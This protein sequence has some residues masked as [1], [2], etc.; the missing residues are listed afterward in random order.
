MTRKP[1]FYPCRVSC[2]RAL[3]SVW[4]TNPISQ[5]PP[6]FL[7]CFMLL[8]SSGTLC[9]YLFEYT[10]ACK[11]MSRKLMG[12]MFLGER[13][14]MRVL[15][16]VTHTQNSN[17]HEDNWKMMSSRPAWT[18]SQVQVQPGVLGET[19]SKQK[20][21]NKIQLAKQKLP[22]RLWKTYARPLKKKNLPEPHLGLSF[23][24]QAKFIFLKILGKNH[25]AL[26]NI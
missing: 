17:I 16:I 4:D 12:Q 26:N 11:Y 7:T 21:Q 24:K 23:G 5:A 6:F 18:I 3:S 13:K 20:W 9:I 22:S 8:S 19:V 14:A 25:W 2:S 15:G 1:L 10:K